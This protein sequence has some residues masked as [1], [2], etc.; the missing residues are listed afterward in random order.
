MFVMKICFEIKKESDVKNFLI[1]KGFSR[2]QIS[3]LLL[4]KKNVYINN[5]PYSVDC[6]LRCGDTLS[7]EFNEE[8]TSVIPV[9]KD[10]EKVYEDEYFLVVNKP[11]GLATIPSKRHFDD[12]L[13]ARVLSYYR[14][15]NLEMGIHVVNRLDYLTCGLVVFAKSG[16]IHQQTSKIKINKKYHALTSGTFDE[17]EGVINLKIEKSKDGVKRIISDNG[18][19]AL[20]LYKVIK[21]TEGNSLLEVTPKT[22]R[23]HQ[24]R[25]HLATISHPLVGDTL[26]NP[27]AKTDD[28]FYLCSC[29]LDF[30]LPLNGKRYVFEI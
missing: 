11:K 14:K 4:E 17:K 27:N 7:V 29:Y 18:K 10:I 21:E 26:Y 12:S 19:D 22:G 5:K 2:K 20:T 23:T 30:T 9:D 8:I 24:I 16:F 15:N 13:S 28:N 25:L 6:S 1:E 3:K